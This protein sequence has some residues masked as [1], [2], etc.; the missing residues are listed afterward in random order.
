MSL[1]LKCRRRLKPWAK[2]YEGVWEGCNIFM[3]NIADRISEK[4]LIDNIDCSEMGYGWVTNGRVATNEQLL[5][6]DTTKC[7]YFEGK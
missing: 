1:C 2:S 6:K 3:D 5:T 4:Q 7:L